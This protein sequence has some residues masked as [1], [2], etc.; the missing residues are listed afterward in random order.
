MAEPYFSNMICNINL[1]L[2]IMHAVHR[3]Y[4]QQSSDKFNTIIIVGQM[5]CAYNPAAAALAVAKPNFF[6]RR[7]TTK[8]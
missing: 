2:L 7:L 4:C 6:R 5:V 8:P 3:N 1:K